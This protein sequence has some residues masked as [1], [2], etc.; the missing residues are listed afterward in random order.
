M[1]RKSIGALVAVTAA[2]CLVTWAS[3]AGASCA[4]PPRLARAVADAKILFVGTV[5]ETTNRARWAIVSVDEVWKG[6]HIPDVVQIRAGPADPLG[7]SYS[8]SSVDREYKIGRRYLFFPYGRKDAVMQDNDCTPT[9]VF[10]ES[11]A[12]F[13][14]ETAAA[15]EPGDLG[16]DDF[17]SGIIPSD[18]AVAIVGAL[19]AGLVSAFGI[20]KLISGK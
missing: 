7:P 19:I 11:L 16:P 6:E 3:P 4:P 5:T 9:R 13:R 8:A 15:P 12:R 10:T 18:G 2:A 20:R 14:P 17:D 1:T